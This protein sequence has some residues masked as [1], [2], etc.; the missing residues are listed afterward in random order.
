MNVV[1][2]LH[3]FR[4]ERHAPDPEMDRIQKPVNQGKTQVAVSHPSGFCT[5]MG[6]WSG[7]SSPAGIITADKATDAEIV[8]ALLTDEHIYSDDRPPDEKQLRQKMIRILRRRQSPRPTNARDYALVKAGHDVM[9][10]S[11]DHHGRPQPFFAFIAG[12]Y[13]LKRNDGQAYSFRVRRFLPW[14]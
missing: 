6:F 4:L 7:L 11:S 1:T 13:A 10:D 5:L 8:R 12:D 2:Y 9:I 14:P 3:G